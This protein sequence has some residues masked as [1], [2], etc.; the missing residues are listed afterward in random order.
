VEIPVSLPEDEML[1]DR[2]GIKDEK[3]IAGIWQDILKESHARGELFTLQLHPERILSCQRALS[4]VLGQAQALSPLVWVATLREIAEWWREKSQFAW[5][6]SSLGGGRHEVRAHCSDRAT[7]LFRNCRVNAH[8]AP[9]ISGYQRV[10]ARSF[11]VE[12]SRRPV[13]GLAPD[14]SPEAIDFLKQEGFWVELSSQP[15]DYGLYL[16][17]LA[18]FRGADEKA[19]SERIEASGAPLIRYWRWPEEAKS[20]LSVT[21]DIDSITLT[22]FVLRKEAQQRSKASSAANRERRSEIAR[23]TAR[24]RW[25][26]RNEVSDGPRNGLRSS[27]SPT[28]LI[29]LSSRDSGRMVLGVRVVAAGQTMNRLRRLIAAAWIGLLVFQYCGPRIGLRKLAH[30]LHGRVVFIVSARP[31]D[32]HWPSSDS[33]VL[34]PAS[35]E[36]VRVC[37][38]DVRRESPEGRYQILIRRWYHQSGLGTPFVARTTDTNEI[39]HIRWTVTPQDLEQAG[40]VSRYP[41]LQPDQVIAENA[42]TFERFRRRG[43]QRAAARQHDEFLKRETLR[44][45]TCPTSDSIWRLDRSRLKG[46]SRDTSSSEPPDE[47]LSDSSRPCRSAMWSSSVLKPWAAERLWQGRSSSGSEAQPGE[48]QRALSSVSTRSTDEV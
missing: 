6:L 30:Q 38:G 9:W 4:E 20:A 10:N 29:L 32:N 45:T 44:K 22:D 5:E 31:L 17:G 1:V 21:G 15:D 41:S 37:L 11:V 14:S 36:E 18:G 8:A 3:R 47:L 46:R 39:C 2:L 13:V 28:E 16:T 27:H 12:S 19:L 23:N 35:P 33:C 7:L 25:A 48:A 40:L 34:A 43:V 24:A 42:Y 26:R